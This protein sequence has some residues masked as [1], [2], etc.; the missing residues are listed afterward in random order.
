MRKKINDG[1]TRTQRYR[2]KDVDAYRKK[3]R[4]WIKSPEQREKRNAYMQIWKKNN[5]EKTARFAKESYHRHKHKHTAY[6]RNYHLNRN[7]GITLEEYEKMCASQQGRC[8]ICNTDKPAR[9][10]LHVDH[11]HETGEVRKLLCSRC[12]G[13]LGWYEKYTKE[14]T[15]YVK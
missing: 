15:S 2:L 9:G 12:N 3:K 7:Y 10:R 1:L 14:I 11:N 4:E 6:R 5:P 8:A 13:A